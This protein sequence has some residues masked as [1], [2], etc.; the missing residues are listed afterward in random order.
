MLPKCREN[1]IIRLRVLGAI[2][3]LNKWFGGRFS[4]SVCMTLIQLNVDKN[5]FFILLTL[6]LH[7]ETMDFLR[8]AIKQKKRIS[9]GNLP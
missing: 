7:R 2:L 4:L 8:E 6:S 5:I 1:E 3:G 9:Y